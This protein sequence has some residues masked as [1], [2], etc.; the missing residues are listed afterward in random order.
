MKKLDNFPAHYLHYALLYCRHQFFIW[1]EITKEKWLNIIKKGSIGK[2]LRI[3]I[4]LKFL[5]FLLYSKIVN[6][7]KCKHLNTF[8]LTI[9]LCLKCE[10]FVKALLQFGIIHPSSSK[11]TKIYIRLAKNTDSRL[12]KSNIAF[13]CCPHCDKMEKGKSF[14]ER[15]MIW[16]LN[17]KSCIFTK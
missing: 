15:K 10:F 8:H 2:S 17:C 9:D 16:C 7:H 3:K 6:I 14:G 4:F 11:R 12:V 13:C 1:K 5:C